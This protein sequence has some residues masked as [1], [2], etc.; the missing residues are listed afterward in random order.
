MLSIFLNMIHA[1][2]RQQ[3]RR[4]KQNKEKQLLISLD[5]FDINNA[6]IEHTN[7]HRLEDYL[8]FVCRRRLIYKASGFVVF[9]IRFIISQVNGNTPSYMVHF[10]LLLC[11]S[12]LHTSFPGRLSALR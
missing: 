5:L 9:F 1:C 10:S 6:K 3:P 4:Y 7:L 2:V 12:L 8:Q 11:L